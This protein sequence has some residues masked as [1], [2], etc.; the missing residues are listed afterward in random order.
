M[1][2]EVGIHHQQSMMIGNMAE[3]RGFFFDEN[4]FLETW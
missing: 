1:S 3:P 2:G 4:H